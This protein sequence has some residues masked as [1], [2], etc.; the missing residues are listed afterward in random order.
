M[1]TPITFVKPDWHYDQY[2]DFWRLVELSGFPVIPI[3]ELDIGKPGVFIVSPMEGQWRPHIG[4]QKGKTRNAHLILWLLERPSGAGSKGKYNDSCWALLNGYKEYEEKD[5]RPGEYFFANEGT[6]IDE[7]WVSD[8]HLAE[9]S[10]PH[11]RFVILGSDKGLGTPGGADRKYQF[12]HISYKTNR[13]KSIYKH[14]HRDTIGPNCW[15]PERDKI[16]QQSRFGLALHQDTDPYQ[17]PLRMAIFAAYK[18]PIIVESPYDAFPWSPESCS[19]LPYDQEKMLVARIK[20]ILADDYAPYQAMA[21]RAWELM[22]IK[23][24]FGDMVREAVGQ[25]VGSWGGWR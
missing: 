12:C 18:L 19:L 7:I 16:L 15:P 9:D 2:I 25:S 11:T 13:R 23:H 21:E 14:F 20:N 17:E 1:T 8:R 10:S 24:R 5:N 6:Y 4:G 22:C 3:G